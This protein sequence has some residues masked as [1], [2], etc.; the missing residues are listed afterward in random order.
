MTE[1]LQPF[2]KAKSLYFIRRPNY[3]IKTKY[4]Y[5]AKE[6]SMN[7]II[8]QKAPVNIKNPEEGEEGQRHII[9]Q[10][11]VNTFV[12]HFQL[13]HYVAILLTSVIS[14]QLKYRL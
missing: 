13:D 8:K 12:Q 4:S 14:Y 6:I 3:Y 2:A 1:D 10:P 5:H 9:I 11:S 7:T